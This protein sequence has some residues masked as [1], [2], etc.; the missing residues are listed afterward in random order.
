MIPRVVNITNKYNLG[1][2]PIRLRVY[3]P[4]YTLSGPCTKLCKSYSDY[5]TYYPQDQSVKLLFDMGFEVFLHRVGYLMSPANMAK[6]LIRESDTESKEEFYPYITEE[7]DKSSELPRVLRGESSKSRFYSALVEFPEL[8]SYEDLKITVSLTRAVIRVTDTPDEEVIFNLINSPGEELSTNTISTVNY[9][10]GITP[11]NSP[12]TTRKSVIE[13]FKSLLDRIK[14]HDEWK[15]DYYLEYEDVG[16]VHKTVDGVDETDIRRILVSFDTTQFSISDN[17]GALKSEVNTRFYNRM[18]S[19][20]FKDFM[21]LS[22][23]SKENTA[24]NDIKV[25]IS[26]NILGYK[27]TAYKFGASDSSIEEYLINK[28]LTRFRFES[29]L[30]EINEQSRLVKFTLGDAVLDGLGPD[31]IVGK[32]ELLLGEYYLE[33]GIG[34]PDKEFLVQSLNE[35]LYDLDYSQ[36]DVI[37]NWMYPE[38]SGSIQKYFPESVVLT[39]QV[40]ESYLEGLPKTIRVAPDLIHWLSPEMDLPGAYALLGTLDHEANPRAIR[41]VVKDFFILENG[42][43][44][45]VSSSDYGPEISE[46]PV[47]KRSFK[48]SIAMAMIGRY[49][50]DLNLPMTRDGINRYV[51]EGCLSIGRYLGI[52][53]IPQLENILVVGSRYSALVTV[54]ID[55]LIITKVTLD[56]EVNI[57]E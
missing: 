1:P 53:V 55:N 54:L 35:E 39:S 33:G 37:L 27:I 26:D 24:W 23:D 6:Y 30:Q 34:Y 3:Y 7:V 13:A 48:Y 47:D 5:L 51:I 25:V 21:A 56:V 52:T 9:G 14:N 10:Y 2:S 20:N 22:I 8:D 41:Y 57:N 32:S 38:V 42:Y 16:V 40:N 18:I 44:C 50:S 15:D 12:I 19:K 11:S 43:D 29:R 49:F 36:L 45:L 28:S 17:L 4:S 46:P 31:D